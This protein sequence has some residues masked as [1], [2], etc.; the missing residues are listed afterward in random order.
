MNVDGGPSQ[1]SSDQ[2]L[3]DPG[4]AAVLVDQRDCRTRIEERSA[5]DVRLLDIKRKIGFVRPNRLIHQ[6]KRPLVVMKA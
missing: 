4:A 2:N 3:M 5:W 6:L 1:T